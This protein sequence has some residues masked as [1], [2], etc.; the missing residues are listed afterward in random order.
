[1]TIFSTQWHVLF[2]EMVKSVIG[3][4]VIYG[5]TMASAKTLNDFC[6]SKEVNSSY[7]YDPGV[8]VIPNGQDTAAI[9]ES[10]HNAAAGIQAGIQATAV[11]E[12]RGHS[13]FHGDHGDLPTKRL[14]YAQIC[15]GRSSS[16]LGWPLAAAAAQQRRL[17][18][19]PPLA[20]GAVALSLRR[21]RAAN[22][23]AHAEDADGH[24]DDRKALHPKQER[25]VRESGRR[26]LH[27]LTQSDID[28]AEADARANEVVDGYLVVRPART[29]LGRIDVELGCAT[30]QHS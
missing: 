20:E 25:A 1:M 2:G 23:K 3:S 29:R 9:N 14:E 15:P 19:E 16:R 13:G 4:N 11:E 27:P 8:E 24:D 10:T 5:G 7:I 28:L 21:H 12:D 6:T 17:P 22:E 26:G 18:T 30:R